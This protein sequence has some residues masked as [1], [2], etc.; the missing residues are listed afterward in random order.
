[1][2]IYHLFPMLNLQLFAEGAG[3]GEGGTAEGAGVT[4]PAAGVQKGAKNPLADVKYGIQEEAQGPEG[5]R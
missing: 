2:K 1:M 5:D 4:A 3:A